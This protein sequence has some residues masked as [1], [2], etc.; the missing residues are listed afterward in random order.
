[1]HILSNNQGKEKTLMDNK[2][3]A[4]EMK[5]IRWKLTTMIMA[6]CYKSAL[7]VGDF[8]THLFMDALSQIQSAIDGLEVNYGSRTYAIQK[9]LIA[10]ARIEFIAECFPVIK[11]ECD[12]VMGDIRALESDTDFD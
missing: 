12:E 6:Y 8:G 7:S 4:H 9:L 11:R 1:M 2:G 5:M 3:F 10:K